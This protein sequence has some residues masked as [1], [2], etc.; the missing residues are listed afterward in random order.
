[1]QGQAVSVKASFNGIL[2]YSDESHFGSQ[3]RTFDQFG[4]LSDFSIIAQ[5]DPGIR[6]VIAQKLEKIPDDVDNDPLDKYYIEKPGLWRIGKQYYR[7]GSGNI[8]RESV[9]AVTSEQ[10]VSS[11][12]LPIRITAIAGNVGKQQ[13]VVLRMGANWGASLAIGKHFGISGTSLDYVRQPTS[14]PGLG[15]GY[16]AAYGFDYS[17]LRGAFR[18]RFEFVGLRQGST[19]LD[20][21][22]NIYDAAIHY[23]SD[24]L[25]SFELGI[26]HDSS[27]GAD[28][29][30]LIGDYRTFNGLSIIPMLRLR[31]GVFYD[32]SVT[33]RV[34][35]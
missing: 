16:G 34:K 15:R 32:L 23:K 3:I 20:R 30:R 33:L 17:Q 26:T 6:F 24:R 18:Y 27:Q 2:C 11:L 7:F 22:D 9:L 31:N 19:I 25:H 5:T 1:M 8:L 21:S 29:Y 4:H 13:G 28:F 14:A 35:V 10:L 12:E